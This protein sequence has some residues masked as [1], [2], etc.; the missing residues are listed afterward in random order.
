MEIFNAHQKKCLF[1]LGDEA[2]WGGD[3]RAEAKLKEMI[4]EPTTICEFKGK[5]SFQRH[6]E[7]NSVD[8]LMK[9]EQPTLNWF[10]ASI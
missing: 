9:Q 5:D 4:T 2:V 10:E 7:Q 3:K 6:R 1:L 8:Q